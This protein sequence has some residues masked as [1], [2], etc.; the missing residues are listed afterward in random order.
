M[1]RRQ[2]K[3]DAQKASSEYDIPF[4]FAFR[5]LY[6]ISVIYLLVGSLQQSTLEIAIILS[7]F[8]IPNDLE[9]KHFVADEMD[10]RTVATVFKGHEFGLMRVTQEGLVV[11]CMKHLIVSLDNQSEQR[12]GMASIDSAMKW[13]D[14]A[15]NMIVLMQYGWPYWSTRTN[16]WHNIL[17]K[18]QDRRTFKNREFL[19]YIYGKK[20]RHFSSQ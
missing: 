15:G 14:R 16:F 4:M 12:T 9:A 1:Q 3:T 5:V 8:P 2:E 20:R 10:C 17:R 18:M 13:D 6:N 19:E 11:R 7:V